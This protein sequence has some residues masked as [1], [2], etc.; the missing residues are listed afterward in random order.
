M[1]MVVV[2]IIKKEKRER[3]T[4][5][6]VD[7]IIYINIFFNLKN[8]VITNILGLNKLNFNLLKTEFIL[9]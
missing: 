4:I 2:I 9:F 6:V 3:F 8:N 7:I 1:M 5:S